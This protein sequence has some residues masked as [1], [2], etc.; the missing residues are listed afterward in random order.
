M[1][2]EPGRKV[3]VHRELVPRT[4]QGEGRERRTPVCS[5]YVEVGAFSIGTS[6]KQRRVEVKVSWHL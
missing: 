2:L 3:V 4:G 6:S 1:P 5:H